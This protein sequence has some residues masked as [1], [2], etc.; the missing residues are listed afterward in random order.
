MSNEQFENWKIG[1]I[2]N[3][4]ADNIYFQ[5]FIKE[6]AIKNYRPA[7]PFGLNCMYGHHNLKTQL[8]H[9]IIYECNKSNIS[10]FLRN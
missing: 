8:K 2:I 3:N 9:K 1:F 5:K 6:L 7:E 10:N 4:F